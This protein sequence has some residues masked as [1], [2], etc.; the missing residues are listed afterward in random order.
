MSNYYPQ[1]VAALEII[2]EDFGAGSNAAL[3]NAYEVLAQPRDVR[4]AINS[5]TEADTFEVKFDYRSFPFDPRSIRSCQISIHMED[6]AQNQSGAVPGLLKPTTE[7]VVLKGF[8]DDEQMQL[9]DSTRTVTFKG[10]DF[11]SVYLDTKWPGTILDLKAPVD[12]VLTSIISRLK[13]TGDIVVENRTGETRLPILGQFYPDYGQLS[14][15]RNASRSETYW[16]VIQDVVSKAGLI[17]YIEVD[18]LVITKPRTLYDPAKAVRLIYGNNI[19]RL[20]LSRRMGKQKGFNLVVRSVIGKKVIAAYIPRESTTLDIR[21]KDVTIPRQITTGA[22]VNKNEPEAIAPF[23]SFSVANVRD[24]SHL[25]AIGEKIFEEIARQ[26][27]EGRLSTNEMLSRTVGTGRQGDRGELFDM[28]KLRNGSPLRVE[29]RH[30]DLEGILKEATPAA[31]TAYL[32]QRGYSERVA[33]I[34]AA[35][36]GKFDTPFYCRAVEFSLSAENG[37]SADVEFINF[38]ETAGKGL[39]I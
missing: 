16:D 24:K 28:L 15:K 25:I 2:L 7:N 13:Q 12:K 39:G 35:T 29:I 27:L 33:S 11:T 6:V 32:V 37:F 9:D 3:Q 20:E 17:A 26:Q 38:I 30:D 8:V 31:R 1:A 23:L 34:M 10:R 22:A 5:Y 36:L 18:K 4:V 21:G 19:K 14:G